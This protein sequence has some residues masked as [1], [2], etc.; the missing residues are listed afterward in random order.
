M[1]LTP[2]TLLWPLYGLSSEKVDLTNWFGNTL[3]FLRTDPSV[4]VPEL[5]GAAILFWFALVIVP[6]KKVYAFLKNGQV[7]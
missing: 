7:L 6:R 4:Y 3:Y 2:Q 1:W 5:V